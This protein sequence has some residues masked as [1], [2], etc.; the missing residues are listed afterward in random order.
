MLPARLEGYSTRWLDGLL[1]EAG[2]LWLGCGRRKLTFCFEQDVELYREAGPAERPRRCCP[3]SG[4]EVLVLGHRGPRRRG[5]DGIRESADVAAR[6]WDLAWKGAVTSDCFVP[7]RRGIAGGFRAEEP[8]PGAARRARRFDRWQAARPGS[9]YWF[10]V[11]RGATGGAGCAGRG[12]DHAGS[13]PPG[14]E[15][16]RRRLPRDPGERAA[17]PAVVAALPQPA[18]HGVLRRGGHGPVLRRG[19]RR[20]V[21]ASL[22][23]G[24]AC[25]RTGQRDAG[26]CNLVG[27]RR[28]PREPLRHRHPG[29][30]GVLPS[31]LS[32][33]HVVFHGSAVVL[34]SRRR[35]RELELRVPPD[36]PRLAEYLSFVKVLTGRDARPMTSF[37]VETI[38]GEPAPASPVQGPPARGGLRG[39]VPP[40]QLRGAAVV[41]MRRSRSAALPLST[42][43]AS[44]SPPAARRGT[45]G[46]A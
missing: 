41:A 29:A 26:R 45:R 23:G 19:A 2:L 43:C 40:P 12:G 14:P 44:R 39:G 18:S 5:P 31:R 25:R 20:A 32:S 28:R 17:A 16:V 33:T 11:P 34:V 30:E 38:N 1:A 36:A 8:S 22:G 37:R 46:S 4:R 24:R 42:S 7:V 9:G 6:L 35:G 13:H 10:A 3:R 27:E 15:A 21:C